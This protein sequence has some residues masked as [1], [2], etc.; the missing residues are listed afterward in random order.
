[1]EE[2]NF[3]DFSLAEG[4]FGDETTYYYLYHVT[5]TP[6]TITDIPCFVCYI[7]DSVTPAG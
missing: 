1:M 6:A 4:G 5:G 3:N 2:N 7:C